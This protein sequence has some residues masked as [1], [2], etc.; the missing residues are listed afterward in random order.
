MLL[1]H[2][3]STNGI[4]E[5]QDFLFAS[6][7]HLYVSSHRQLSSRGACSFLGLPAADL[8]AS[9][10]S[11][12]SIVL[13]LSVSIADQLLPTH[14]RPASAVLLQTHVTTLERVH[15][16]ALHS[17]ILQTL[18][19]R[20]QFWLQDLQTLQCQLLHHHC[21]KALLSSE[22]SQ[23]LEL[24]AS[25]TANSSNPS[26]KF[27]HWVIITH[28]SY[29]DLSSHIFCLRICES[30]L[31]QSNFVH[32]WNLLWSFFDDCWRLFCSYSCQ[33]WSR[34]SSSFSSSFRW[35]WFSTFICHQ[36]FGCF[37]FS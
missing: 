22:T 13:S 11:Y 15:L 23:H 36:F 21:I 34:R 27:A 16:L 19:L 32:C 18:L 14:Y 25:Q 30:W 28:C 2:N 29:V 7:G 1:S 5:L 9:R 35:A 20:L 37:S 12:P 3:L 8:S 31:G 10:R 6:T 24:N 17:H 26:S 33:R 4:P